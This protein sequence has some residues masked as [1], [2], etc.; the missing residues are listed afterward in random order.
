M[1]AQRHVHQ[2]IEWGAETLCKNTIQ[3]PDY[4]YIKS[5]SSHFAQIIFMNKF[6]INMSLENEIML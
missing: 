3:T 1:L 5:L 4:K 2:D 6:I